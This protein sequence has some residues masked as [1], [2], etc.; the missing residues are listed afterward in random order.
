MLGD[1]D[2]L[3]WF[4]RLDIPEP[5]RSL[6]TQIRSTGP[7]RRVGGGRSNVTGRYPSKKMG[8]TIQFESHQVE[9][10]GI[11]EMEHD[12]AVLEYFDQ[13]PPIRLD[14]QSSSGK[15]MGVFHTPDFFVIKPQQA[16]WEEWK[17]EEEL[18]RLSTHNSFRYCV[19]A[20][21]QWCCPPGSAF[22][23]RL[24]LYYRVRSSSEIDWIFQRNIQFLE[25]YLRDDTPVI[26]A[27]GHE[28]AIA[29]VSAAPGL[30]LKELLGLTAASI[31]PDTIFAMIAAGVLHV[32]LHAAPLAEPEQVK[33]FASPEASRSHIHRSPSSQLHYRQRPF[34]CGSQIIWDERSFNVANIGE[35]YVSLISEQHDLVELRVATFETLVRDN[36]LEFTTDD[37]RH[38]SAVTIRDRLARATKRRSARRPIV[39]V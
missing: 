1:D 28:H 18:Q 25:D 22:A 3:A 9:L 35:T 17:T 38:I 31:A 27:T 32:N 23:E 21:G 6:I 39:R 15:R 12:T 34:Q 11:H 5:A 10:A 19:D 2:L 33:V 20:N 24:G 8:V 26:P 16:G 29:Q 30:S 37:S 36:R 13:P 7:S 4:S 14:Y